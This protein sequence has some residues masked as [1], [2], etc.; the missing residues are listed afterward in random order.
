MCAP[1]RAPLQPRTIE[2][3]D[4]SW[5]EAQQPATEENAA[6]NSGLIA[7]EAPGRSQDSD[8]EFVYSRAPSEDRA[9]RV[10]QLEI[11]IHEDWWPHR[12]KFLGV[13]VSQA[14]R[15][16]RALSVRHAPGDFW[17]GQTAVEAASLWTVLCNECHGGR[18][19]VQDALAMPAPTQQWSDG[20]GLFFGKSRP[21]E[22]IFAIVEGGGPL[23]SDGRREMPAW[24]GIL[25][26]EM[27]WALLYFLEYQSGGVESRFP[28]SLYPRRPAILQNASPSDAHATP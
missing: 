9:A 22:Q 14:Q 8:R 6:N 10:A 28:P 20:D 4:P 27:M 19:T 16:D 23:Q 17:D 24:Q 18:R 5:S 11:H 7:S 13:S 3:A 25:P 26:R 21:Y 2:L 1:P 12:A 15:R